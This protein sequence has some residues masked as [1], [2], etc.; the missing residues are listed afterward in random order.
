MTV[1]SRTDKTRP[2]DQK[3]LDHPVEFHDHRS[4]T[5]ELQDNPTRLWQAGDSRTGACYLTGE[6]W[7]REFGCGRSCT[8]CYGWAA[9]A[10]DRSARR[11][12]RRA[13]RDWEKEY[14]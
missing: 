12:G 3:I 13:A 6:Y 11:R 5:C 8:T 9:K 2:H 10:D 4:G 7:R 14:E 1:V